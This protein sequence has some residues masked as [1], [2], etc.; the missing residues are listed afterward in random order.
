MEN[1][2]MKTDIKDISTHC[3]VW[4]LYSDSKRNICEELEI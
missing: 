3:S 2:K 1:L 4:P